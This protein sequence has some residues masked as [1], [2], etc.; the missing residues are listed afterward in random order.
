VVLDLV[1]RESVG[2]VDI[3]AQGDV[4][5]L[6]A[7]RLAQEAHEEN[8]HGEIGVREHERVSVF[9][10]FGPIQHA[11]GLVETVSQSRLT[12]TR[13]LC[14]QPFGSCSSLDCLHSSP[15][16]GR[17]LGAG[18][19]AHVAKALRGRELD[20]LGPVKNARGGHPQAS[21][22]ALD[23]HSQLATQAASLLALI[24]LSWGSVPYEHMFDPTTSAGRLLDSRIPAPWS[25]G[26]DAALSRLKSEFDPRRG[27]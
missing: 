26:Q 1:E 18:G 24:R 5:V 6:H 12:A 8:D 15:Y 14:D 2:Q 13:L 16:L 3:E 9:R 7:E 23:R 11:P 10:S 4:L 19:T 27:Y 20:V 21:G 25:N 17:V 22:D